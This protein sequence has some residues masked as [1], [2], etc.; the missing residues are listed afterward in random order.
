[1]RRST[2][3]NKIRDIVKSIAPTAKVILF[4]SQARGDARPE[5]DIDLLILLDQE[6]VSYDDK[7]EITDPIFDLEEEENVTIS[8]IVYS[9]KQWINRPIKSPF[10]MNVM[11]EG[12]EL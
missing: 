3:I 11:N 7:V 9:I 10:Y 5:S 6:T 4:G 2:T 8:P 12:I 1:M